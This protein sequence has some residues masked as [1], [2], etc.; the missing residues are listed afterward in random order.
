MTIALLDERIDGEARKELER[1]VYHAI[2]IPSC[3]RLPRAMASHPDMLTARIG[4]EII[5]ERGYAEENAAIFEEISSLCPRLTVRRADIKLSDEYPED[6]R[7]NA[8]AMGNRLFARTESLAADIL[9]AAV[10]L[11]MKI[12]RVRQ[13]YPAC[14]TLPLGESHASTADRGRAKALRSEGIEVL[15][16][17]N[18]DILLPPYDYGFI[19]GAAGVH[20]GKVFFLGDLSTHRNAS[21]IEAFC[22]AA[23]YEPISLGI[24]ALRDLGRIIFIDS[25]NH[26]DKGKK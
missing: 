23:S 2:L 16:I 1:A 22:R 9:S 21:E 20:N 18:G 15:L 4:D 14:T 24:G 19:G 25:E 13:G 8:L 26:N 11:G 7:L 3:D 12:I 6:C 17:E 5:V 10:D